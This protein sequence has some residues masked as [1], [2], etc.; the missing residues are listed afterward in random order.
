[1]VNSEL[2]QHIQASEVS[3]QALAAVTGLGVAWIIEWVD[4]GDVL[5]RDAASR[6]AAHFGLQWTD[7]PA[8]DIA[9]E[10]LRECVHRGGELRQAKCE[11]CGGPKL[12]PV[13]RCDLHGECQPTKRAAG[14]R[15]CLSC[16]DFVSR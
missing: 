10:Q 8:T 7:E 15:S 12:T 9:T 1:M 3:A 4:G 13:M 6:L 14:V 2:R 16:A 5:P 11:P